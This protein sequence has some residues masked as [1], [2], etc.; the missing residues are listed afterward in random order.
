[1]SLQLQVETDVAAATG[2]LVNLDGNDVFARAKQRRVDHVGEEG[3]ALLRELSL[4]SGDYLSV[5]RVISYLAICLA[6]GIDGTPRDFRQVYEI[7]YAINY[8]EY[9]V[10]GLS[11]KPARKNAR[12]SSWITA[13]RV[14]RGTP[15]DVPGICFTKD[16]SYLQGALALSEKLRENAEEAKRFNIGKYDPTNARHRWILDELEIS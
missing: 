8:L 2:R 7:I 6:Y 14:F 4:D 11:P 12:R 3:L 9:T 16:L 5:S 13:V 15:G 1:M 10:H